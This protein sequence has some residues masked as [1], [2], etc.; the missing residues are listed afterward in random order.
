MKIY[1]CFQY[2]DEDVVLDLRFNYLNDF[3]DNFIIVESTFT[4]SGKKRKTT[5][6]ISK[7]PKFKDKIK[8]LVLDKEPSNLDEIKKDD[9]ELTKNTKK[10][11]NP[12][13]R[14]FLQRELLMS[15][16]QEAAEED[17]ILLSD[18]DEIPKLEN[19]NLRNM[20]NRFIF[21]KQKMF[22]YKFNLCSESI[23]WF[24]TKA[25]KKKDLKSFQWL[26]NIKPKNYPLWRFDIFFHKKKYNNILFVNDGGWHFSYIKTPEGIQN[27]LQ[28]Y[29]HHLEYDL[30][31]IGVSNI[32]EKIKN[33]ESIYNL[34]T[35]MKMSNS[36]FSRGQVLSVIDFN[37][38]P[39]YL[40]KNKEKFKEW[41]E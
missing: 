25:C 8:Y 34:N 23:D 40:K 18:V 11:L 5:F 32:A 36:R 17:I 29:A 38:L 14:E 12:T 1:A 4:H 20:K 19:I 15:G 31:P 33:K 9:D 13:K 41:L 28:S 27:K 22:Y 37:H 24:G 39:N 21:F 35:D 6:D 30:N 26:R 7:Y 10:I 16:I 3:V 2:M